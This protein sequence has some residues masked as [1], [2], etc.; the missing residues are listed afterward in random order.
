MIAPRED[1][2]NVLEARRVIEIGRGFTCPECGGKRIIRVSP[3]GG[4]VSGNMEC[5]LAHRGEEYSGMWT[6]YGEMVALANRARKS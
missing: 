4:A 5:D 2:R 1:T 6:A 3:D